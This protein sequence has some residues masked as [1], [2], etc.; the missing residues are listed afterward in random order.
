M[1][2]IS[3][4]CW[5]ALHK[6]RIYNN[7]NVMCSLTRRP[8]R[9]PSRQSQGYEGSPDHRCQREASEDSWGKESKL[10]GPP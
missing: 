6:N 7:K 10:V 9:G 8:S 3:P 2:L 4:F 1:N 5:Y